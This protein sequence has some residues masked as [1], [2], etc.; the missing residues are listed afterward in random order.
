M[1]GEIIKI[2]K[3]IIEEDDKEPKSFEVLWEIVV[4]GFLMFGITVEV[5]FLDE[6]RKPYQPLLYAKISGNG[7]MVFEFKSGPRTIKLF[8]KPE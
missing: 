6:N 7:C 2:Y 8:K 5:E 4:E 3:I 1:I